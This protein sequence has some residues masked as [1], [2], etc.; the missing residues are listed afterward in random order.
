VVEQA[1]AAR[2]TLLFSATYPDGV[3]KLA[4]RFMRSPEEVRLEER[5]AA[6]Q[7]RQRFIEV[8][9]AE[10]LPAVGRLLQHHRPERTLAFC[11][12]KQRCRDLVAALQAD[13]IVALELHGDLEQRDRDQV[14]VQFANRSCSVLVATD[15]AARGLDIA[16]L[17]AVINVDISPEAEVH[18]HRVGRTGRGDAE[19]WAF[20]LASLDEME[21]VARIDA[22][23]GREGTW[24]RLAELQPQAG[25]PLLP[26][27]VTLQ[28][29][30]G[31]KEK[32]RPGDV[33]GALTKDLGYP[34]AQIGKINV[35]EYSTYVA[36][37][38]GIA[39]EAMRGLN[40]GKVKGRSVKVRRL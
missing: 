21:Y 3:T 39:K 17:E 32:I 30:G 20:S 22:M 15:V 37:D 13:G 5:P 11:N 16:E 29:L 27:M 23:Q 1:P 36:V 6:Q 33:L 35:N 28:I 25:E 10:R 7:I 31:R 8:T 4:R 24:L 38:R 19:G 9:E 26:P 12:T 18:T 14:L 2:Q 40:N 34:S